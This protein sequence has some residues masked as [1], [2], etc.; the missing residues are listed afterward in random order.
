MFEPGERWLY[1]PSV[2]W[3]GVAV[4]SE[5][6]D[7][8]ETLVP[9]NTNSKVERVTSMKLGEYMKQ[10]I[11]DVVSAKDVTFHLDQREDLRSRKA[12]NW[13]RAGQSLEEEKNPVMPDPVADDHGGGGVYAT[14]SAMLK[15]YRGVLTETLL[16]PETIKGMF[17]PQLKDARGLGKPDEYPP[18]VRNAIWNAVPYDVPVS[19]GLGGLVNTAAVPEQRGSHSLTWSGIPNCYWV[20]PSNAK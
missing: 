8:V 4:S 7:S 9:N 12:K 18:P 13:E 1:S 17:Q 3:A 15:I 20:S 6:S 14:V 5:T 2:D 16:R 10:H 11:F 19:F